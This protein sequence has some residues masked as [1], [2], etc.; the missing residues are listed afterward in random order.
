MDQIINKIVTEVMAQRPDYFM[1]LP[2]GDKVPYK[3]IPRKVCANFIGA[4]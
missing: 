1:I 4:K 2:N 3:A